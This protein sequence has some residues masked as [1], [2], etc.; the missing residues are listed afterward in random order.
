MASLIK[1]GGGKMPLRAI[2]FMAS[3]GER[4]TIR[5]GRCGLEAAREFK[6]Q[7]EILASHATTNTPLDA[8]TSGW[9]AGLPDRMH[10]KLA[11]KGLVVLRHPKPIAPTLGEWLETYLDQRTD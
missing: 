6:R 1:V 8:A 9:L 4:R 10:E 2:Q 5:L 3:D 7:V 11:E